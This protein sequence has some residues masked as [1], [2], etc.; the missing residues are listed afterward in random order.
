M[1]L[2]K[3]GSGE[4]GVAA[5]GG[6]EIAEVVGDSAGELPDRFHFLRLAELFLGFAQGPFGL[7]AIGDVVDHAQRAFEGSA[8]SRHAAGG[9]GDPDIAPIAV[10]KLHFVLHRL[11]GPGGLGHLGDLGLAD[12][13]EVGQWLSDHVRRVMPEHGSHALIDQRGAS[14]HIGDPDALLGGIDDAP[15]PLLA[16]REQFLG[17]AAVGDVDVHHHRAAAHASGQRRRNHVEP[18][19]QLAGGLAPVLVREGGCLPT[20]H[21]PEAV[22]DHLRL[23]PAVLPAVL[24]NPQVVPRCRQ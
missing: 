16:L 6:E 5:D 23:A 19:R 17:S 11:T 4:A 10:A 3:G 18:S 9:D 1:T 13:R 2:G 22:E 15:V 20:E 7:L 12:A 14:G 21:A 24:K 8:L